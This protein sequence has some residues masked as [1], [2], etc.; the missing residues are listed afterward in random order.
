MALSKSANPDTKK[1]VPGVY[2]CRLSLT[3]ASQALKLLAEVESTE[4][5]REVWYYT[6]VAHYQVRNPSR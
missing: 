6:A 3:F 4:N 1:K 2:R 5:A